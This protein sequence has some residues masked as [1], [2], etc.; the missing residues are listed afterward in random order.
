MN[1]NYDR[2]LINYVKDFRVPKKESKYED[3]HILLPIQNITNT[4]A[5][6][7]TKINQNP[8]IKNKTHKKR[9]VTSVAKPINQ[10]TKS[11]K[12]KNRQ[13]STK[14]SFNIKNTNATDNK[15]INK[16]NNYNNYN[17]INFE[18]EIPT[19]NENIEFNEK[20]LKEKREKEKKEK[21]LKEKKEKEKKEK[22][23][24]FN[25][26]LIQVKNENLVLKNEI[27]N[28]DVEIEK[29]KKRYQNQEIMIKDLEL[30]ISELENNVNN[31]NNKPIDLNN[32]NSINSLDYDFKD[33]ILLD[34]GLQDELA[35]QAVDQQIMDELC[36]N[37]DQMTYEQLL[38]L[39]DNVGNVNK[40]LTSEQIDNLP[41]KRFKK[42][43]NREFLQCI[44]CMEEFQEKEK[45]KV[46]PCAHIFHINCIKQWLLKQKSCPFCKSEIG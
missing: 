40:G 23:E 20:E 27:L 31:S 42:E 46:L 22:K 30:I 45:V 4:K 35:L 24:Y 43:K 39:E 36:P 2:N 14:V 26:K 15:N 34:D 9:K 19:K 21:K 5:K 13:N 18:N 6:E 10:P 38:Q 11:S 44:I 28:K 25:K 17:I 1:T 29:Y 41:N 12:H 32:Y 37:P 33:D 8:Y 3:K 16:Y 7:D